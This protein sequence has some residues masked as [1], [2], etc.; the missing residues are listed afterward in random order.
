MS[1]LLLFIT[2]LSVAGG[3]TLLHLERKSRKWYQDRAMLIGAGFLFG[4]A[5]MALGGVIIF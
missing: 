5:T 1:I 3:L 2:L 4:I